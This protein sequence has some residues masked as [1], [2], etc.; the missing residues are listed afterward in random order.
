MDRKVFTTIISYDVIKTLFRRR[1]ERRATILQ[2][3]SL[4]QILCPKIFYE[5][6]VCV[7]I[8]KLIERVK[9]LYMSK[10]IIP[11]NELRWSF[12]DHSSLCVII[13]HEW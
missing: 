1:W 8:N 13:S 6:I 4:I 10:G 3:S 2:V 9:H 12:V 11:S 7:H 5:N